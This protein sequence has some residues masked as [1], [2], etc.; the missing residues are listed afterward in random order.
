MSQE[1]FSELPRIADAVFCQPWMIRPSF[2]SSVLVPR[3][4]SAIENPDRHQPKHRAWDDDDSDYDEEAHAKAREK[5]LNAKLIAKQGEWLVTEKNRKAALPYNIDSATMIG[6]VNIT[7]IIGKALSGFAMSCG[8]VCVDQ[9]QKAFTHLAELGAKKIKADFDTPGGTVTG[10]PECAD[11]I[12]AFDETVCPVHAY[13]D[14]MCCSAGY[15]LAASA[16]TLTASP[17]ADLGSI[18]VYCAIL[19]S[20]A[21]YEKE[22]LKMHRL[23]SGWAKGQGMRGVPVSEEY[24]AFAK[25][26][27]MDHARRFWGHIIQNRSEQITAEAHSLDRDPAVHAMEIMQGQDW[28]AQTAPKALYDA[29]LPNRTAHLRELIL[30]N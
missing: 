12:A 25:E 28:A 1:I 16:R 21:Y 10:V 6:Q 3:L 26:G 8:G 7:G 22:G 2:H 24:L 15:Y 11:F 4:Q 14:T 17:T 13:T 23:A 30:A 18:G 9:V 29:L 5:S 27:V 20:S 19:D